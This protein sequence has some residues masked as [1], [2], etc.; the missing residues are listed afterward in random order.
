MDLETQIPKS[1]SAVQCTFLQIWP[2]HTRRTIPLTALRMD[3][4]TS[5]DKLMYFWYLIST[6][7]FVRPMSSIPLVAWKESSCHVIS[8]AIQHGRGTYGTHKCIWL[9]K[10]PEV[11]KLIQE[12][13][14]YCSS[15]A[16]RAYCPSRV[17]GPYF[18]VPLD[19]RTG[20]WNWVSDPLC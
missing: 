13:V 6:K 9:T 19:R 11:I 5:Y 15:C 16:S 8:W 10:L 20:L 12:A 4:T 18:R 1:C 7:T 2:T 17:S 14:V 3:R